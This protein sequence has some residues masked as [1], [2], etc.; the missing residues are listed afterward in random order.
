MPKQVK[1]TPE[2][3]EQFMAEIFRK[4]YSDSA[5]AGKDLSIA[6]ANKQEI[7]EFGS[8]LRNKRAYQI[9]ATVKGQVL[10]GNKKGA[11]Q[12]TKAARSE[13]ELVQ[14]GSH[15][16]AVLVEGTPDQVAWLGGVLDQLREVGLTHAKIDHKTDAYAVVSRA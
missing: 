2:E 9:R 10:H 11:E 15:R 12:V 5:N 13:A 4:F 6:K 3:R 8:M 1:G 7:K 14:P 16:V